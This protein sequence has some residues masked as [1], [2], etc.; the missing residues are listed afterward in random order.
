[1]KKALAV[2]KFPKKCVMI[3]LMLL[4]SCTAVSIPSGA[5]SLTDTDKCPSGCGPYI[6]SCSEVEIHSKGQHPVILQGYNKTCEYNIHS[7]YT[8][9]KCARCGSRTVKDTHSHG[10]SDHTYP[11]ICGGVNERVCSLDGQ[12]YSITPMDELPPVYEPIE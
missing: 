7:V 3:F 2:F 1:M 6:L 12:V 11:F 8:I 4:L 5:D 9:F 10:E